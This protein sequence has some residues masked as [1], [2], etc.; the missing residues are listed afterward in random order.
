MNPNEEDKA[1][2]SEARILQADKHHKEMAGLAEAR[3][4][5]AEKQ[6]PVPHLES[7]T[8]IQAK[9]LDHMTKQDKGRVSF[10][11]MNLHGMDGRD[12][13]DGRPGQP[14]PQGPQGPKGDK[15]DKGD[16][17]DADTEKSLVSKISA[18]IPKVK[19][20]K[21]GKDGKDAK[22]VTGE[23]MVQKLQA[24]PKGKRLSFKYLDDT[25]NGLFTGGGSNVTILDEGII[26]STAP[27]AIN[28]VGA[29]VTVTEDHDTVTVTLSGGGGGS[30]DVVGP[31]SA[32][33]NAVARYDSTTGK[34]LQNSVVTIGDTGNVAGLGTLNTHTLQG[35]TSTIALYTNKLSVFA[36]TTSSELAGVISDE[37]G[38]GALV[39][40]N[41][42]TLVTPVI[43]AAT[44]TT[45]VLSGA[46]TTGAAAG[47][48]GSVLFKGTTS[49]T[50]TLSVADAAG[51]WTMKLPT[52][53]GS[54]GQVL[55]T[56]GAGVTSWTTIAGSGDVSKVG[57]P[58]NNQMAVWTGDGTLEGTSDFTYDGTS[59]NLITGKNFQIAGATILA[60][61]AGTT[62]LSNID[63][64][65]ATTEATIEA[66]IDTLS[67]L[68]SVGT[69][70]IGVWNAGAVT[71]TGAF[72]GTGVA[73]SSGGT[74]NFNSGDVIL[75]HSANALTLTGG[76]FN[77]GTA[78]P[79]T[80]GGVATTANLQINS[81]AAT[82]I[83][84]HSHSAT[85]GTS[86]VFYG[87]RS[88]GTT[89]SPTVVQSGDYI[90]VDSA[91]A[92][93][94]TDYEV[95]GYTAWI[96]GGTPGNNDMPGKYV[97][98]VTPD[99]S[100]TAAVAMT[101]N[102]DATI[103]F[104]G[105]SIS[106]IANDGTALGTASLMF[107]D[108]FLASGAVVNFNNG[109]VTITHSADTLTIG[110]GNV[111]ISSPGTAAGSVVTTDGA[112]TLSGKTLTAPKFADLGFIA[113]ANGNELIILDTVA[114]AVN[115]ITFANAATGGLPTFSATGGD[116]NVSVKFTPKGTGSFFGTQ[117][118][119]VVAISDEST[120]ITTGTAKLTFHMP[121]A[122]TL[123]KV[124][125]GL[126]TA[127]TSGN[128][129]FDLN[130]DGVSVFSTTITIDA[131]ES[132]SDTAATASVLTSTPLAIASGSVMTVDIDTAGT[133][134]KGAKLYLIGYPTAA[135]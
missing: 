124:K 50:V 39:F 73:I 82:I 54:N 91:V 129:A 8:E 33:D 102:S 80:I 42:P 4:H 55:A 72:T 53:A 75:T 98:A 60:D 111:I 130:D 69:I 47:T 63:A 123:M 18:L 49:G 112:Q 122:F 83:E 44:G 12:G 66:A 115:E 74:I 61:A 64:L 20:G 45:L 108:V 95:A 79:M 86:A 38:T 68:T 88:R 121:Y 6:N 87:V 62:T 94:G 77:I 117:E 78:D 52:G 25:P 89:A 37:T 126:S 65:D 22:E 24:L 36:A 19:D 14:G 16:P 9:Q 84:A 114:S 3:L 97:I 59:L 113:D 11:F 127:S 100:A 21:D 76:T 135:A 109:D 85:A 90:R 128:P 70:T 71:S 41:T 120:A 106:P 103:N 57:T 23:S 119:I 29:S 7:M 48:T 1:D 46:L 110:G 104:S 93:D 81:D 51:T 35:G 99:G 32:T 26:V 2:L 132:F 131:N 34:L 125:A 5:Q 133:G 40:A 27:K 30:G 118:T 43:G 31:A 15:G 28:F 17:F 10:D 13:R 96:V 134:A 116:S 56:D 101:V 105:T 58:S 67:N 107:S 92:Y